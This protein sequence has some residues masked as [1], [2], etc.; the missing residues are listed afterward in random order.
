MELSDISKELSEGKLSRGGL[1]NRLRLLGLGFGAAFVLGLG[2]AQA[3]TQ[4]DAAVTV[5]STNP[6]IDNIIKSPLLP[7][8]KA[9]TPF[10]QTAF[11]HRHFFRTYNRFGFHRWY[12]RHYNRY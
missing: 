10:K 4:P 9:D 1:A 8:T 5:K 7:S 11:Y 3:A 6:V 2:G 12:N